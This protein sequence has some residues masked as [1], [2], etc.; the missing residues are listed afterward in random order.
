MVCLE[1]LVGVNRK[2]LSLIEKQLSIIAVSARPRVVPG[3]ES[4]YFNKID[5]ASSG[6]ELRR[7]WKS[8]RIIRQSLRNMALIPCVLASYGLLE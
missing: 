5:S 2:L 1:R 6:Q 4:F 8:F 7:L 3:E